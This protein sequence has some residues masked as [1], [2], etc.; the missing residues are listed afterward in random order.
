MQV[1]MIFFCIWKWYEKEFDNFKVFNI[2]LLLFFDLN[3]KIS[4]KKK[5]TRVSQLSSSPLSAAKRLQFAMQVEPVPEMPI[6]SKL[7]TVTVPL[8]WVEESV[9]LNTTYTKIFRGLYL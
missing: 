7:R 8:F 5:T 1:N 6:M 2:Q 9:H 3:Q 4:T